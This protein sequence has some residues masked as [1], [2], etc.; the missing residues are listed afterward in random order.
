MIATPQPTSMVKL[1]TIYIYA[2][3]CSDTL[4]VRYIG[5]ARNPK[6]RLWGHV[7]EAK[8][9]ANTHKNNWLNKLLSEG[10]RPKV[11]VVEETTDE[12]WEERERFWIAFYKNDYLTNATPGGEGGGMAKGFKH[13]A[14]TIAKMQAAAAGRAIKPET[15][16]KLAA[17]NLGKKHSPEAK[18]KVSSASTGRQH[19]EEAKAKI[20]AAHL[21]KVRTLES[22]S[23]QATANT[24]KRQA[25]ET[26]AKKS[27]SLKAFYADPEARKRVSEA[28]R[29][30][31]RSLE[32]RAKIAAANLGAKRS[33]EARAAM[34]AAAKAYQE[35]RR[36]EG[37]R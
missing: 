37:A 8:K 3:K 25:L 4:Q 1:G 19:T 5:K 2:L 10:K 34:S 9:G 18:D 13:S 6:K 7:S 30:K 33:P 11:E 35:R 29:G 16:A 31:K 23:K 22:C 12:K 21:G 27:A 26:I 20:A 28:G 32:T 14:E 15:K 36:A 17:A 24:G